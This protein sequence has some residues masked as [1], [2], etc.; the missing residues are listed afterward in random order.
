MGGREDYAGKLRE[1]FAGQRVIVLI[2]RNA[3]FTIANSLLQDLI[4]LLNDN[5]AV[6]E[7]KLGELG[8]ERRATVVLIARSELAVPQIFSPVMMPDWWPGDGRELMVGIE[9]LTW[10]VEAPLDSNENAIQGICELLFHVETNLVAR[11]DKVHSGGRPELERLVSRL[12]GKQR[13]ADFLAGAHDAHREV[14]S[15]WS[16]RPSMTEARYLVAQLWRTVRR[17]PPDEL[18]LAAKDLCAALAL[19]KE[20]PGEWR[21]SIVT[22]L[23][24]PSSRRQSE[25]QRFATNVFYTVSA[26]CQFVT[27]SKHADANPAYPIPP[28]P[29]PLLR[30]AAFARLDRRRPV[31]PAIAPARC[32]VSHCLRLASVR[33]D[34][35]CV[36]DDNRARRTD[37]A[38]PPGPSG[39]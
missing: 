38:S 19:P 7:R 2:V 31:G 24:R 21:E 37:A 5:R 26:A 22:L 8:P 13:A 15:A 1:E 33:A 12:G 30:P 23:M 25:E 35:C 20:M 17:T 39:V 10:L 18:H 28:D 4:A 3:A 14:S 11:L 32:R 34:L 36:R 27:V 6:C 29:V 16:F 9:D